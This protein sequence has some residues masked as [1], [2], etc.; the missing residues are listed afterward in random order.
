MIKHVIFDFDGTIVDSRLLAIKS[1]NELAK[2]YKFQKIK[3]DA[4]ENLRNL[5]LMGRCRAIH[6]PLYK[7]P[8]LL[9]EL[10]QEY[11]K[12]VGSLETYKG[13]KE[14]IWELKKNG[15]ILSIISSNSNENINEF[16]RNSEI[17]LFDG[18]HSSGGFF[19]KETAIANFLRKN[20]LNN[21]EVVYIGDECRDIIACKKNNVRV[22][23]VSW[24]YESMELLKM[25]NPNFIVETPIQLFNLITKEM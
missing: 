15:F 22:I 23:A 11:R 3:E 18:I 13:L 6:L 10:N 4:L 16:L 12:S 8:F 17:N 21:Q 20:K 19:N 9:V 2:K 24:G 1:I 14:V 5:T 7:L 25:A